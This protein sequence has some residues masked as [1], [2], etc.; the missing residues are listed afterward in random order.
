MSRVPAVIEGVDDACF[1]SSQRMLLMTERG[2]KG[3]EVGDGEMKK[4]KEFGKM[5]EQERSR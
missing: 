2:R 4:G 1:L 3:E 5:Q